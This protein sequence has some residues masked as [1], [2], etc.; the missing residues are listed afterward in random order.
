MECLSSRLGVVSNGG[1][2]GSTEGIIQL[3]KRLANILFKVVLMLTTMVFIVTGALW[4]NSYWAT[5]SATFTAHG[6]GWEIST[7][8]GGMVIFRTDD[9]LRSPLNANEGIP[10]FHY[11]RKGPSDSIGIVPEL[12]LEYWSFG[13]IR[14]ANSGQML[15]PGFVCD[16]TEV[17]FWPIAAFTGI[18]TGVWIAGRVRRRRASRRLLA[19]LC[20]RCGYDLR[21]TPER[22]PECGLVVK[23]ISSAAKE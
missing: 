2:G 22:C 18:V 6:V 13:G 15:K 11:G 1:G 9:R 7:F 3:L 16:M 23:V 10:P 21:A 8:R 12:Y 5:D 4:V 20:A 14:Y 19:G 17:R